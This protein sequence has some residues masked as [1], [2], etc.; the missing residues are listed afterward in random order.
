MG[1]GV[2]TKVDDAYDLQN[3]RKIQTVPVFDTLS[4]M[5]AF[6]TLTILIDRGS[7]K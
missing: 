4:L 7:R 6:A 1:G 5:I 3:L 2:N